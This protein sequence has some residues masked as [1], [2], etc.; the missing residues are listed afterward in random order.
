MP[1]DKSNYQSTGNND[2]HLKVLSFI[3]T[4]ALLNGIRT[5]FGQQQHTCEIQTRVFF[6]KLFVMFPGKAL[7]SITEEKTEEEKHNYD[8]NK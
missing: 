7:A 6:Q 5:L 8:E 2:H 4:L 3:R 1:F